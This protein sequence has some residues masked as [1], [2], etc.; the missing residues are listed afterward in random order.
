[1]LK[2]M[3]VF[4]LMAAAFVADGRAEPCL[5]SFAE[6]VTEIA[7]DPQVLVSFGGPVFENCYN[8]GSK[9]FRDL[10]RIDVV[11]ESAGVG[12]AVLKLR[13]LESRQLVA[14]TG[15]WDRAVSFDLNLVTNHPYQ[16]VTISF[17]PKDRAV[18]E[19]GIRIVSTLG[20]GRCAQ[21]AAC[22]FDVATG[23]PLRLT[24]DGRV[25]FSFGNVADRPL[26]WT[27]TIALVDAFGHR[28]EEPF[29]VTADAAS[30]TLVPLRQML[31]WRG[32]WKATAAIRGEDGS[33]AQVETS[34]VWLTPRSVT[35]RLEKGKF[36][37][38]IHNHTYLSSSRMQERMCDA[39]VACGAKL[40]RTSVGWRRIVQ[41]TG[42]DEWRWE[43]ED[44][45]VDAFVSR[46]IDIDA[47]CW[48][49]PK[50]AAATN[51]SAYCHD[52]DSIR[53]KH[54]Q[55]WQ[56]CRPVDLSLNED[57]FAALAAR[58]RGRIAYY[59]IGNEWD[60]MHFYPGTIDDAV[61]ILGSCARGLRRGDADA[62][63]STCGFAAPDTHFR[64]V[65][66]RNI[67]ER[68]I[69]EAQDSY[70]VH[71]VHMHGA[72]TQYRKEVTERFLPMRRRLGV[73][74]PWFSNESASTIVWGNETSVGED[75][76]KK[77]LFAWAYGSR[78]YV[79]YNL[80][81]TG[82]NPK[83]SEQGYGM[84]SADLKPRPSYAAF[85]ALTELLNGFDFIATLQSEKYGMELF[86]FRGDREGR[87]ETV[88]AGW[89]NRPSDRGD[90]RF[91]TPSPQAWHV[92]HM[93][94]RRS[95]PVENGVV[96]WPC[97]NRPAALV[98]EGDET[99]EAIPEDLVVP[100]DRTSLP[101]GRDV[102]ADRAPDLVLD[103]SSQ[104]VCHYDANPSTTHRTWH[105]PDDCSAKVWLAREDGGLRLRA[106][107]RDDRHAQHAA[108]PGCMSEGDCLRVTLCASAT[109]DW[110]FG[111]R[112]TEGGAA[113]PHCW[114]APAGRSAQLILQKVRFTASRE[115]MNTFYDV[116]LPFERPERLSVKVDDADE[117]G[118]DL[119]IGLET[120]VKLRWE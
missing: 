73:T 56:A 113:E 59:E 87:R 53:R 9:P 115:G 49:N 79:W 110:E 95:L 89:R 17:Q 8:R 36:R 116:W 60:L 23:Q 107:V 29:D 48:S 46:G 24:H 50:W 61:K 85:A 57:Y 66:N 47:L 55:I 86:V 102:S 51:L 69:V 40:V 44:R 28:L 94:N 71:A 75:V 97:D 92:D 26:R 58:F 54:A 91:R 88:V 42:P 109:E 76:W 39:L 84:L 80:R 63:V 72:F 31:P 68:V 67:Q 11:T 6:P 64:L 108:T 12:R 118:H 106:V 14:S 74:A 37:M 65:V 34:L 114:S 27:G 15:Q 25:V 38:G 13:D 81:G 77:I 35:P 33:V 119:W 7:D 93:G 120:P 82:W 70:D 99:P 3:W 4:L 18:A 10:E 83:D 2:D 52:A 19:R 111:F 101:V 32:W 20:R 21:A 16:I 30:M 103:R 104:V 1:M 96:C 41:P 105:G 90:V 100:S 45:R 98:L 22:R 5:V 112:L 62:V 117:F 78:D 43:S